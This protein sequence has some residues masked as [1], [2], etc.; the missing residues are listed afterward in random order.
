[1]AMNGHSDPKDPST[2]N[3]TSNSNTNST[4]SSLTNSV[5][6][7]LREISLSQQNVPSSSS[8][9]SSST[10]RSKITPLKR[11]LTEIINDEDQSEESYKTPPK[12]KRRK[13]NP[14][15]SSMASSQTPFL[16]RSMSL[17]HR[18]DSSLDPDDDPMDCT[19]TEEI[20]SDRELQN[21]KAHIQAFCAR[22]RGSIEDIPLGSKGVFIHFCSR[23]ALGTFTLN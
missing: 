15:R 20:D 9:S 6:K 22:F 23:N 16:Q 14:R 8:S 7:H 12:V 2:S 1:M 10:A 21:V 19:K 11:K 5:G 4:T 18:R 13:L 17:S 3:S